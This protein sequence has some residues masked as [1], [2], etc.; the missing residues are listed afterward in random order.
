MTHRGVDGDDA[1]SR[2]RGPPWDGSTRWSRRTSGRCAAPAQGRCPTGRAAARRTSCAPPGTA[3]RTRLDV[4]GGEVVERTPTRSSTPSLLAVQLGAAPVRRRLGA[5]VGDLRDVLGARA[6]RGAH[7]G[8]RA[9]HLAAVTGL[10]PW[11][12]PRGRCTGDNGRMT[13]PDP[14][15]VLPDETGDADRERAL[16]A[17]LADYELEDEDLALLH[18]GDD[19]DDRRGAG[20]RCPVLAIVGRPNVGKS[21]LVNRILGRR[22]A[23]V[24][25]TPRRH[26]RPRELQ[27]RVERP[28]ASPSSTPAAGSPT[29]GHRRRA[30]P[31]RP[32]SRSTSPTPCCSS[33]TPPSAP[34]RPTSRSCGCCAR[35]ASRSSSSP[36]RST[37]RAGEAGRRRRCGT[38]ASASRT[39]S[40]PCT[41]AASPTCSTRSSRCSAE[42]SPSPGTE[43]G[44]PR[45]VAILGRPNVG[46]S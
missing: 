7:A 16:R 42:V 18:A 4:G 46:K 36:T 6:V 38:S 26:P 1:R 30:S 34:P 23:V 27:G 14:A 19:R 22:E 15:L 33:S 13:E 20:R 31:R 41:A 17:G 32:R 43:V 25:D 9:R 39:R 5:F 10:S 29:R 2:T 8:R 40:P 37:T 35:R 45:R 3:G 28:R 12:S 11:S 21:A 24:E 44:G